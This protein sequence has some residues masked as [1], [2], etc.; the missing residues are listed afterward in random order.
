[1]PAECSV[2]L[3][4]Y[5]ADRIP[6]ILSCGHSLCASCVSDMAKDNKLKCPQ[7]REVSNTERLVT[8][9]A[10]LQIS[11]EQPQIEELAPIPGPALVV[12]PESFLGADREAI[13]KP[14][15]S[16]CGRGLLCECASSTASARVPLAELQEQLLRDVRDV[17]SSPNHN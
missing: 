4:V 15:W 13:V 1:M 12:Q 10:L 11:E 9:F 5:A 7:C 6:K 14:Y 8:N 2:C 3:E 16:C 17:L